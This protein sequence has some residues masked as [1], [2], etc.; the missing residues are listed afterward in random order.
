MTHF[1][2]FVTTCPPYEGTLSRPSHAHDGNESPGCT[3]HRVFAKL[4]PHLV[5][6]NVKTPYRTESVPSLVLF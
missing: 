4:V 2:L 6:N 5:R 3:L 1:D